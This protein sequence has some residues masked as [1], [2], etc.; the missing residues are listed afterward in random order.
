MLNFVLGYIV[1]SA[2]SQPAVP[3]TPMSPEEALLWA[4]VMFVTVMLLVS[5]FMRGLK[6]GL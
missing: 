1:G 6:R 2:S 3:A 4:G 5:V